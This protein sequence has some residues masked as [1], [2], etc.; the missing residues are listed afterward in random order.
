LSEWFGISRSITGNDYAITLVV[1]LLSQANFSFELWRRNQ[2]YVRAINSV[3]ELT[4]GARQIYPGTATIQFSYGSDGIRI[5]G[6]NVSMHISWDAVSPYF[7][8]LPLRAERITHGRHT[9]Y[10]HRPTPE[11]GQATHAMVILDT[12]AGRQRVKTEYLVIPNSFFDAG[13]S[14]DSAVWE[15]FVTR[16]PVY[17]QAFADAK[18][19]RTAPLPA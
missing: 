17:R 7:P 6:S 14:L 10:V 5:L 2:E 16:I 9:R 18:Q 11:I 19:P 12:A 1:A 3:T 13:G 4:E 15:E 8:V